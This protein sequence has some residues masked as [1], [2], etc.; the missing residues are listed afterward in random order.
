[1]WQLYIA[2]ALMALL[3]CTCLAGIPVTPVITVPSLLRH[4]WHT[5]A[6]PPAQ[7]HSRHGLAYALPRQPSAQPALLVVLGLDFSGSAT[8]QQAVSTF[9]RRQLKLKYVPPLLASEAWRSSGGRSALYVAG[10]PSLINHVLRVK[11]RHLDRHSDISIHPCATWPSAF[12]TPPPPAHT[13]QPAALCQPQVQQPSTPPVPLES[14][15]PAQ[16][17]ATAH[18]T[19]QW[20]AE[21]AELGNAY[22]EHCLELRAAATGGQLASLWDTPVLRQPVTASST[23]QG[24]PCKAAGLPQQHLSL[25]T[26]CMQ[27]AWML[28]GACEDSAAVAAGRVE[29]QQGPRHRSLGGAV[30][31]TRLEGIG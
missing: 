29:D 6:Q 10:P 9:L 24:P 14:Q 8:P 7:Q 28:G 15:P 20:S 12:P 16:L 22:I 27:Q 5:S 17:A 25:A 1:M 30:R 4:L 21:L 19:G 31:A 11:G 23:Q 3:L 2:L 13:P 18:G 26:S